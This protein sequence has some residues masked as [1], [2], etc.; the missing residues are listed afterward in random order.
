MD[1]EAVKAKARA[2]VLWCHNATTHALANQG[3]PWSYLLIP[4]DAI[5]AS[6]TLK[7]LAATFQ[8]T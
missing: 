7:G 3:K 2:A 5:S 8:L 1:D 6:T 4:H